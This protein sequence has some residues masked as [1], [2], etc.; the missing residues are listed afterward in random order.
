MG[1]LKIYIEGI[2]DY[3]DDPRNGLPEE[4]F[5]FATEITPMVNVD[6][7]VRDDEGRI[8]LAWRDDDIYGTGWHVPGGNNTIK[9][10]FFR[11]YSENGRD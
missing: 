3:I 9:G 10:K 11:T 5:L 8:L 7:L 4:L 6:L 1:T 2:R